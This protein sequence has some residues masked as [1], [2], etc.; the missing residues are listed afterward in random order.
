MKLAFCFLIYDEINQEEL[1]HNFFKNADPTKFSIYI[2]YKTQKEL[3]Y[4]EKYKL[5]NCIPTNY[6]DVTIINAHNLLFKEAQ[7]FADNYKFINVSQACIPLKS[8]DYVYQLLT[9]NNMGYFN[10]APHSASFPRCD[11]LLPF[12]E[13]EKIMKSANWFIL[14]RAQAICVCEPPAS[15]IFER[16]SKVHTPE[17]HY[18]ITRLCNMGFMPEIVAT[19]NLANGATTFC[20]WPDM[21]YPDKFLVKTGYLKTY[22]EITQEEVFYLLKSPCLFGRKFDKACIVSDLSACPLDKFLSNFIS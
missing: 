2:H 5:T 8:F 4:F 18:F 11:S 21:D 13:R 14:N 7:K 19:Q 3:K 20:N 22:T 12:I 17:E 16:Y 9:K 1:W 10:I 6:S 15:V